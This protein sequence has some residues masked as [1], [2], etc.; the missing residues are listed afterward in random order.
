MI[1]V[2]CQRILAPMLQNCTVSILLNPIP[3][4][5]MCVYIILTIFSKNTN[6]YV[7]LMQIVIIME[8]H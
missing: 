4:V 6:I 3:T 2:P 7:F 5:I 8:T 1:V